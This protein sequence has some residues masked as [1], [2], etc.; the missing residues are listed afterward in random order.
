MDAAPWLLGRASRGGSGSAPLRLG[1]RL[2]PVPAEVAAALRAEGLE[3]APSD[4][5]EGRLD[6]VAGLVGLSPEL[7]AIVLATVATV[8]PLFA[9]P[10]F[11]VSHSQ[12][13]WRDRIFVSFPERNDEVGA[14]RLAESVVHEAMHLHLT[15]EE[16]ETPLVAVWSAEGYSPWRGTRRS[17]QGVLHGVFVFSCIRAFLS[18]TARYARPGGWARRHI[19]GRLEDIAR[20]LAEV[21]VAGLAEALTTRGIALLLGWCGAADPHAA[22]SCLSSDQPGRQQ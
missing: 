1:A 4:G 11:D 22:G 18:S 8:H 20:E 17:A 2:A 10:G 16:A 15:N 19:E 6:A 12:P 21:D 9:D 7:A 3:A 14:L 5:L 13:R